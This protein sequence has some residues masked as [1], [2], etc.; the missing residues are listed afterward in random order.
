MAETIP[1]HPIDPFTPES[2]RNAHAVDDELREFAPVVRLESGLVLITRHA[3]VTAGLRDWQTFS[4]EKEPDESVPMLTDDPPRHQEIRQALSGLL[5]VE[6][7]ERWRPLFERHAD[8]L[9]T[10]LLDR[11]ERTI[12]AVSELARPFVYTALPDAVGVPVEGRENMTLFIET[13]FGV[14]SID[15]GQQ[16]QHAT[17]KVSV[18]EADRD[19]CI[20]ALKEV[21]LPEARPFLE[22]LPLHAVAR[23]IPMTEWIESCCNRENIAK[24][25]IGHEVYGLVD[26]GAISESDAKALVGVMLSATAGTEN[27]I[28]NALHAFSLYPDEYQ[29]VRRDP[30]LALAVFEECLR[31]R[32]PVRLVERTTTKP[33]EVAGYQIGAH[34]HVA[35]LL[36]AANRDPR[37]WENP[38]VFDPS[39][40]LSRSVGRGYG[41]HSCAGRAMSRLEGRVMLEAVARR[42]ESVE[43]P[44]DGS[45]RDAPWLTLMS[46]STPM[47]V[48]LRTG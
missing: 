6:S 13:V 31:W 17:D 38:D 25:S 10:D 5:T 22:S 1:D 7:L 11:P 47:P 21:G 16:H 46:G 8:A 42:V 45:Q 32:A 35:F 43:P 26:D 20:R 48:L 19:R 9:L 12:D 24:G 44:A 34:Q 2:L 4:S 40:D 27:T 33:V 30:S 3:E 18:S 28:A 14:E 15:D 39:R 36:G 29:K 23:F 37:V 41:L